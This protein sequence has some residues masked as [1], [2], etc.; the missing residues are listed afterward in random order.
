[1]H[2]Y[3]VWLKS[4]LLKYNNY[5][6]CFSAFDKLRRYSIVAFLIHL[7]FIASLL[8]AY[9]AFLAGIEQALNQRV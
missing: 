6:V 3:E 7:S 5:C 1:M 8:C 2:A 9:I 4:C